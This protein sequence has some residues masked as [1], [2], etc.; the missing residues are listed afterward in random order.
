ME[1]I[2]KLQLKP[3]QGLESSASGGTPDDALAHS[4]ERWAQER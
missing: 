3:D 4:L 1:L 2:A